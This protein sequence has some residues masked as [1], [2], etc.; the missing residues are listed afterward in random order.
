MTRDRE[1]KASAEEAP[2]RPAE[3]V[4][5]SG[6]VS[7]A[8]AVMPPPGEAESAAGGG[9]DGAVAAES[10]TVIAP[11]PSLARIHNGNCFLGCCYL[12][13]YIYKSGLAWPPSSR[14]PFFLT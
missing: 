4:E 10:K 5:R 1:A 9:L 8:A 6:T 2:W 12:H 11:R 14:L 13:M 3:P 7:A